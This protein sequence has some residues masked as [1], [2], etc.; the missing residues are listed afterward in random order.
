MFTQLWV[1]HCRVGVGWGEEAQLASRRGWPHW[2]NWGWYVQTW[3]TWGTPALTNS[4]RAAPT[5]L[6]Q[7]GGTQDSAVWPAHRKARVPTAQPARAPRTWVTRDFPPLPSTAGHAGLC[8]RRREAP[9]PQSR[10]PFTPVSAS[11]LLEPSTLVIRLGS[12]FIFQWNLHIRKWNFIPGSLSRPP[13]PTPTLS[14]LG[15][16]RLHVTKWISWMDPQ[17]GVEAGGKSRWRGL[18]GWAGQ[19]QG[20][21]TGKPEV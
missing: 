2:A 21:M 12:L 11:I 15:R 4:S 9:D 17:A 6:G 1:K 10:F 3:M 7:P 19:G 20:L 14:H 13:P 8:A 5:G 18:G 16:K